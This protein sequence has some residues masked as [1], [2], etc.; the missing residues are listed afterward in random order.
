MTKV[1]VVT[2]SNG[3]I[4]KHL[5]THLKQLGFQVLG[6][7]KGVD[8]NDLDLYIDL[9]LQALVSSAEIR[10]KLIEDLDTQLR[11]KNVHVLVNNAATQILGTFSNLSVDDLQRSLSV[12]TVAPFVLS[13]ILFERLKSQHGTV[14]NIGS[15]HSSLT[16]SSFLAYSTS[17]AAL[18]GLTRAMAIELGKDIKVAGINPAAIN[19][20][21]LAAG[22]VDNPEQFSEL[23]SYHPTNDIGSPAEVAELV[24]FLIEK[25]VK[26]LN[27]SIIN[28]DGG[29]RWRLHDPV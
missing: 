8:V 7:D 11:G 3:G 28:I 20:E 19:T 9:D 1:A 10:K 25:P 29:I 27:G 13:Q 24:G 23:C 16:K 2:G 15:I 5:V 6:I 18:D 4:G 17:K 26:F 14:V 21:M 22:F 12:N